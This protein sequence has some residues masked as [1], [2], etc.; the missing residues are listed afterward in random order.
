MITKIHEVSQQRNFLSN[1]MSYY[2]WTK[3]PNEHNGSTLYKGKLANHQVIKPKGLFK[4][5]VKL[6]WLQV[7]SQ[8]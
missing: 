1:I 7:F 8:S 3:P 5:D 2:Q 4:M 6:V